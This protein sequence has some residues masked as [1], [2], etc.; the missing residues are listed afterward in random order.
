MRR[1]IKALTIYADPRVFSI[2]FLGFSSGLPFL[3]ILATLSVWLAEANIS[4]TQIGILAWVT[5]PYSFKFMWAP[6]VDHFKIPYLSRFLGQRRGWILSSQVFLII[7]LLLLGFTNPKENLFI[8]AA[9]A[10]LVGIC[11]ASQDIAIEAYR[12]EILPRSLIGYGASASVLGYRLGMLVSGAGALYLAAFFES[13]AITYT[14]MACCVLIGVIAIL[15]SHE[16]QKNRT[17]RSQ[18]LPYKGLQTDK[19][20]SKRFDAILIQ[21]FIYFIKRGDWVLILPF[22]LLYKVGDT[23]LNTMSMPFLIE[24]GF[25]KVEIAHVAKTFGIS[26]MIMGGI[27]GGILSHKFS[28]RQNLIFCTTLQ[29]TAS[30]FFMMQASMGHNIP[31]LFITMGVENLACGMSQVALISYLS[32]L[33][34]QPNTATHY[35]LLSSFASFSRVILS[36]AAGWL[37][38]QTVWSKF[39][40]VIS[41]GCLPA[42]LIVLLASQHFNNLYIHKKL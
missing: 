32:T 12:I 30:A 15:L 10:F 5:I 41:F 6:L 39:Y 28:L 14:L 9:C 16:P 23:V 26:A 2:F 11:S 19:N 40:I 3:L 33:C 8:T 34:Q 42:L 24:I 22:I 37:A 4:K 29:L 17:R 27:I 1:W 38:D 20:L 31:F 25:S 7:A 13:W 35:A 36:T 21:P 18:A